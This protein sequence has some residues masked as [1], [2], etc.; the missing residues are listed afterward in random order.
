MLTPFC[1]QNLS[2]TVV[3]IVRTTIRRHMEGID[4]LNEQ[5][6]SRSGSFVRIKRWLRGVHPELG[7]IMWG[8]TGWETLIEKDIIKPIHTF[9][10]V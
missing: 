3:H 1:P 8:L 6:V 9:T 2:V 5:V 4:I 10:V 7:V